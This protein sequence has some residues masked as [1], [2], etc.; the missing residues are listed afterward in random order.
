VHSR[1]SRPE[2]PRRRR[3]LQPPMERNV[4][5]TLHHSSPHFY[6]VDSRPELR[7]SRLV[8]SICTN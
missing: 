7:L 8:R 6:T 2:P 3:V 1:C 5:D 4:N